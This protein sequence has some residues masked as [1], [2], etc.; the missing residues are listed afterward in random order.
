M[1]AILDATKFQ[2][3]LSLTPNNPAPLLKVPGHTFPV[4]IYYTQDPEPD[5]FEAA[6]RTVLLIHQA[7][8]PGDILVFLT[9]EEEIEDACKKLKIDA[10]ELMQKM[11]GVVG[12]ISC[13][14]L[15]STLPLQEQQGIF[16]APPAARTPNGPPG[17]KVVIST[18]IAETSLTIDGIV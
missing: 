15:Y 18:N 9:G 5:Y 17:R 6:M 12:P 8:D 7:E 2:R 13:V 3:Y 14:P 1:S 10:D 11:P 4:G 16:D